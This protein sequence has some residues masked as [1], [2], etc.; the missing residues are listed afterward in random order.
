MH[1]NMHCNTECKMDTDVSMDESNE[2]LHQEEAV[3]SQANTEYFTPR[4]NF[5]PEYELLGSGF[6]IYDR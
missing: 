3:R 1:G 5:V 2:Y 4:S 6:D